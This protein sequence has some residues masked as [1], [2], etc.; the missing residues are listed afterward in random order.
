MLKKAFPLSETPFLHYKA[1]D[2]IFFLTFAPSKFI[3]S[4]NSRTLYNAKS[5]R[6][7]RWSRAGYA[8]FSSLACSVSIG[9]VAVSISDKSLQ[10]AVGLSSTMLCLVCSDADSADS[11]EE[12]SELDWKLQQT[13]ATLLTQ[14]TFDS[15]AAR[16]DQTYSIIYHQ[17][18]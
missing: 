14:I 11:V 5:I 16:A 10:K 17:N 1:N 3:N 4:M 2:S 6:F 7:R 15:A 18:G 8:I 9:C 13:S 12:I